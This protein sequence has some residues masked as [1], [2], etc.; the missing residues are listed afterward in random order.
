MTNEGNKFPNTVGVK[1]DDNTYVF[2]QNTEGHLKMVAVD[3]TGAMLTTRHGPQIAPE[4]I[5]PNAVT[6]ERWERGNN[7]GG[8]STEDLNMACVDIAGIAF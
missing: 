7:G 4:N 5:G 3:S 8:Y 6:K 2:G 1:V